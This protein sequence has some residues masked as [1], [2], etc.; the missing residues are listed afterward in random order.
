MVHLALAP[1]GCDRQD[2]VLIAG[3]QQPAFPSEEDHL[4]LS[5]GANQAAA[6]LQHQRAAAALRAEEERQAQ[7]WFFESMDRVNRATQGT[8]DLEQMMSEV[9]DAVLSMFD[10]D[11]A[12]LVYPCD[13]EAASWRASMERTRPEFPGAFALGLDL[14]VDEDVA[15]VFRAGR[16]SSGPVR[17]G[18]GSEHPVP[19]QIRQRFGVQ[20]LMAMA[21]YPK[22]DQPYLLGLHQCS[23]P[24]VWT[25]QEER[26]FQETGRRLAD[27]LTTLLMFR[28]LRDSEARLEEAQ[29]IAHVGYWVRDLD[30]DRLT[31]SDES[32]RIFGLPP[33]ELCWVPGAGS[34]G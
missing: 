12:W 3:S 19:A 29:R 5:V 32:Y 27:A 14:P 8:N 2:G 30:T 31:W 7:L 6:V 28:N 11:R 16:A 17:F 26:L 20:S 1:I 25:P 33:Q 34:S 24:R 21:A 18:P 10:C 9:L 13:P 15:K 4:L 23:Y 22:V